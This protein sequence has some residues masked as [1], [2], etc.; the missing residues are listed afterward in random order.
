MA[1]GSVIDAGHRRSKD[2]GMTD[3]LETPI[4]PAD[5]P[6]EGVAGWLLLLCIV[7]TIIFPFAE[8]HSLVANYQ[9]SSSD[10]EYVHGLQEFLWLDTGLRVLLAAF[11]MYTGISLWTER[12]HALR[13][14]YYF[15]F[16]F[17]FCLALAILLLFVMVEWTPE[18]L[19]VVLVEVA[20]EV[21]LSLVY[22]SV[23]FSYLRWSKRVRATFPD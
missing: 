13:T 17:L 4:R 22:F 1:W 6:L 12:P 11:S 16:L 5:N 2:E 10:F 7:F 9:R 23:C 3:D 20:K 15:L 18:T 8:V 19:E 14:A 21:S